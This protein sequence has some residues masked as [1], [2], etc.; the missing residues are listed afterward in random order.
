[1]SQRF[2]SL[3][4]RQDQWGKVSEDDQRAHEV[5][6]QKLGNSG[7]AHGMNP[8]SAASESPNQI[9]ARWNRSAS[10]GGALHLHRPDVRGDDRGEHDHRVFNEEIP[11]GGVR[12]SR[13]PC[14]ETPVA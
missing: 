5:T 6:R 12:A 9:D 10:R 14:R 11:D 1:M 3:Q 4:E 7:R 13:R 2:R 8:A